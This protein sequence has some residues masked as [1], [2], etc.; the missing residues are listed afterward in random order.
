VIGFDKVPSN[1]LSPDPTVLTSPVGLGWAK[2]L[3]NPAIEMG[4]DEQDIFRIT[5]TVGLLAAGIGTF[6]IAAI[7]L[8]I[9]APATVPLMVFGACACGGGLAFVR[10]K[11]SHTLAVAHMIF[12]LVTIICF[13]TTVVQGGVVTSGANV[14]WGLAAPLLSMLIFGQRE[15]ILWFGLFLAGISGVILAPIHDMAATVPS[16]A[17]IEAHTVFNLVLFGGLTM[18]AITWFV[19]QRAIVEQQLRK[20]RAS[21]EALL[22]NVL[23]E[24]VAWRLKDGMRIADAHAAVSVLFADLVG[25]TPLSTT[26]APDEVLTM[27]DD[28][29]CEF[30]TLVTKYGVEKIK[31]IGDCYMMA[32]GVPHSSGHCAL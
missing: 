21:S 24:D 3:A 1:P 19:Q 18:V 25:F 11:P 8:N 15:A 22:I 4:A 26:L 14:V 31:T 32:A 27:L 20:E 17:N 6:S 10:W 12:A 30:D 29:F 23:P 13:A 28:L 2:R 16:D 5:L 9:V 7:V